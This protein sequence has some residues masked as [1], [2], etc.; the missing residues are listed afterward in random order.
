MRLSPPKNTGT[1]KKKVWVKHSANF[2]SLSNFLDTDQLLCELVGSP[3]E[4]KNPG[5]DSVQFEKKLVVA[6]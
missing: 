3:D 4:K 5:T 1:V 2:Q 6:P